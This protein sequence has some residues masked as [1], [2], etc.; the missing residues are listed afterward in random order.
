MTVVF[1]LPADRPAGL[2]RPRAV[3]VILARV[4]TTDPA[5]WSWDGFVQPFH[6]FDPLSGAFRVRYAGWTPRTALRER[7]PERRIPEGDAEL[8]LVT[9]RGR[10][11]MLDLTSETVL[12]TL[13]V[14]DRIS[15]GRLPQIRTRER[16]DAFLDAC[17]RLTDLV[18]DWWDDVHAI[19]YRSRAT[20]SQT[21]VAFCQHADLEP[22]VVPLEAATDVL[23]RAVLGDGFSVPVSWLA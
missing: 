6:R 7:F 8:H 12:D 19:R 18:A 5:T 1:D 15:T 11:R 13:G 20:P 23:V 4:D 10:V 2:G 22:D 17:G 21:N 9:L 16:P 3:D 14:D